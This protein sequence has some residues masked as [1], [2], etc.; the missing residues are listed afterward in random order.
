[1]AS[2][3]RSWRK[4]RRSPDSLSNPASTAAASAGTSCA[5]FRPASRASSAKENVDPRTEAT[6]S[7]FNASSGSRLSRRRIVRRK[8]GGNDAGRASA[9]PSSTSIAP[10]SSSARTSSITNS[11]FPAAPATCSSSRGPA[12]RPTTSPA[13]SAASSGLNGPR[14][15]AQRRAPAGRR[16][17]GQRPNHEIHPA[18]SP[19]T[20]TA[21]ESGGGRWSAAHARSKD[22]PTAD[23]RRR[24]RSGPSTRTPPEHRQTASTISHP[25]STIPAPCTTLPAGPAS[26]SNRRASPARGGSGR[27]AQPPRP[28]SKHAE[29]DPARPR[30][31]RPRRPETP[32]PG[33][34]PTLRRSDGTCRSQPR[35]RPARSVPVPSRPPR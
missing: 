5:G 22:Q 9:R 6:R 32:A 24:P 23:P 20:P 2:R 21:S 35:P 30:R 16:Q 26:A 15:R 11:G 19:T 31:T 8:V 13:R 1:M 34:T 3:T 33:Q 10:S 29:D 17:P 25:S 14:T 4:A 27:P 28:R 18:P 7:M 12:G